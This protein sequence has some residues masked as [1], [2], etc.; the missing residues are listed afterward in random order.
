MCATLNIP[1]DLVSEV[2]KATGQKSKTKA[3]TTAMKEFVRQKKI[4][5]L[6]ALRGKVQIDY[7]WKKEEELE[8]KAQK[9][10]EKLLERK[11]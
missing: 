2:Q 3:I 11:R 6:I 1:D 10:R 8:M 5:Q 7:D 9:E 4:K